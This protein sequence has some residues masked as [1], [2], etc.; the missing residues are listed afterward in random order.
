M[1]S[2]NFKTPSGFECES[3]WPHQTLRYDGISAMTKVDVFSGEGT[4]N[5][6]AYPLPIWEISHQFAYNPDGWNNERNEA[7]KIVDLRRKKQPGDTHGG[8][9]IFKPGDLYKVFLNG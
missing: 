2:T 7:G 1:G 6:N 8:E 3:M 4:Y 5:E 9:T